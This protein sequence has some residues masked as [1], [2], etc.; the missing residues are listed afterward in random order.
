MPGEHV[1]VT[2]VTARA[3]P[4]EGARTARAAFAT[5]QRFRG[6]RGNAPHPSRGSLLYIGADALGA[7]AG[8][9]LDSS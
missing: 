4:P 2:T 6:L 3:P 8:G 1:E 5:V 7:G 9:T